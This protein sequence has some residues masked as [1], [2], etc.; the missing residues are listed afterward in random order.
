ME[1]VKLALAISDPSFKK[2]KT[3]SSVTEVTFLQFR[4]QS[5]EYPYEGV[6][7]LKSGTA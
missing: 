2:K 1:V 7:V 6:P 4:R 3:L 5:N